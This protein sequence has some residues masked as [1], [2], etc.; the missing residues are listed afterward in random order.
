MA[1]SISW[2][3]RALTPARSVNTTHG[4]ARVTGGQGLPLAREEPP[5]RRQRASSHAPGAGALPAGHNPASA[6]RLPTE[7]KH[8]HEGGERPGQSH[9]GERNAERPPPGAVPG[10]S[11]PPPLPRGDAGTAGRKH[12]EARGHPRGCAYLVGV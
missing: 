12:P 7:R 8:G 4:T 11:S 2:Q 6:P 3:H 9:S 1:E 5:P 10:P